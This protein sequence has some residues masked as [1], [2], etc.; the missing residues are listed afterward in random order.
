MRLKSPFMSI[1]QEVIELT[2]KKTN[3]KIFL[4]KSNKKEDDKWIKITEN[5]YNKILRGN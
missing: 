4:L 5:E 2:D 1:K 3:E